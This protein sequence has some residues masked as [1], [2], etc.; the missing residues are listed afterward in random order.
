MKTDEKAV[1]RIVKKRLDAMRDD[2]RREVEKECLD[3]DDDDK[4]DEFVTDIDEEADER[5]KALEDT[6]REEVEQELSE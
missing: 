1:D 5:L 6:V 4:F 3:E 2:I